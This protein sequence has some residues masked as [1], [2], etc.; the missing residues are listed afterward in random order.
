MQIEITN[1]NKWYLSL[2]VK[3]ALLAL[4]GLLLLVPLQMIKQIIMERQKNA[5][6]IKRKYQING[7]QNNVS[8][9]L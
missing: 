4:L 7:L 6:M 5:E 1:Q 9:D 8:Q 3:L 2:T